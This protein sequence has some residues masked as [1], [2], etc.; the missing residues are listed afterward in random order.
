MEKI[1][2]AI[3]SGFV[4][5]LGSFGPF[6]LPMIMDTIAQADEIT[7]DETEKEGLTEVEQRTKLAAKKK[8]FAFTKVLGEAGP[9]VAAV[10]GR[11]AFSMV[12][13]AIVQLSKSTAGQA[14]IKALLGPKA[15]VTRSKEVAPASAVEKVVTANTGSNPRKKETA[16]V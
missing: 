5:V 12:I 4:K 7:L 3:L 15:K 16:A 13:D 1:L 2:K 10:V 8:A 6:V 11:S 14:A 9:M